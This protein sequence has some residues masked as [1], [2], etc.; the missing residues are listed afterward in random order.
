MAFA[1]PQKTLWLKIL[2]GLL[3]FA[4]GVLVGWLPTGYSKPISVVP[5]RDPISGYSLINPILYTQVPE[6]L[7]YPTYTPLENALNSYVTSAEASGKATTVA[8]YFQDLDSTDWTGVNPTEKFDPASMLKVATLIALLRASESNPSLLNT[9]ITV[10]ASSNISSEE[11]EAYFPAVNPVQSGNTYSVED[12]MQKLIVQSD[13]GADLILLNFLGNNAISTVFSDLHI[14]LP[15]TTTGVSPQEY[16]H[17]FRILYNDTYLSSSDSEAALQLLTQTTFT[18]GL[19]AGVPPGTVVAHKFGESLFPLVSEQTIWPQTATTTSAD[20]PGL[21]DC[22]IIY[23][24]AHPYFLCVMTQGTDFST[25][26][27]VIKNIS[28]ITWTQ[29]NSLHAQN[30]SS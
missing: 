9:N 15:G 24:P 27:G 20:V 11:Q 12:L 28:N 8:V 19:V 4:L 7:S 16:S 26:A 3:I 29:V 30:N 1:P 13:D 5:V 10:P 21:N 25:L 2:L 23:Y 14:P 22:G 18:D 17:L 6:S